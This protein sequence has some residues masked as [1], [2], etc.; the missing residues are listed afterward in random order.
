MKKK[1]IMIVDHQ[2]LFVD[3]LTALIKE[4]AEVEEILHSVNKADI[5]RII[6]EK[7]IDL[8]I[9]DVELD[10]VSGMDLAA[11]ILAH[12]YE[13]KLLFISTKSYESYSSIAKSIGAHGY[14]TKTET[15]ETIMGAVKA[16][17]NG[18]HIF[19]E[20]VSSDVSGVTL[21]RRE[22]S[23]LDY[24]KKGYNNKQI[25]NLLSLSEKTVSTYKTRIMKKY[26]VN[27]LVHMLNSHSIESVG[28][29]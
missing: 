14:V 7:Q 2:L 10:K 22:L 3:A 27:S 21:S 17:S 24:L 16:V 18:Y 9:M 1:N 19:K 25:S 28:A 8:L 20:G 15:T 29:Y 12:G 23:V 6:K 13:G 26:N 11:R 5:L 4:K